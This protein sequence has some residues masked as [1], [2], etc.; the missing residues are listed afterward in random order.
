MNILKDK[1]YSLVLLSLLAVVFAFGPIYAEEDPRVKI[2]M[3]EGLRL[4]SD[5]QYI[6]AQ[7]LFKQVL[8]IDP[9]N[10]LAQQYI[11]SSE[12]RIREWE[13]GG[14]EKL[15]SDSKVNWDN[16][17]SSKN[18]KGGGDVA[19]AKDIIATRKSLVERMKNRSV[20]AE[21]IVKIQVN[22]K[23]IEV[24]LYHDQLFLPGLL[25]LRDEA[26]PVLE[27][28]AQLMREKKEREVVLYSLAQQ[29]S[30]D[31]FLLYPDFPVP[32]PDPTKSGKGGT[33]FIFQ[34][35]E[36]T[37]SFI[38]FTYLAQESMTPSSLGQP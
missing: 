26:L 6:K 2:I 20:N 1:K 12:D 30:T 38:L 14:G 7:D 23:G 33:P 9:A 34:D 13:S 25:I 18:I 24:I 29:D 22:N 17:L 36:A 15:P 8:R 37:R 16:L 5:K 31:P 21:N 10:T 27:K 32:A 11:K 4:Y 19:N 3:Q 35:I 28:V